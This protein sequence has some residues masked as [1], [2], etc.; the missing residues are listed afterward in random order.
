MQRSRERQLIIAEMR[1][2]EEAA[3]LP[4]LDEDRWVDEEG[5]VR[6]IETQ[7]VEGIY[8]CVLG[9]RYCDVPLF[10]RYSVE[11]LRVLGNRMAMPAAILTLRNLTIML[12]LVCGLL[13]E[14]HLF[15]TMVREL[16][17]LSPL[18][19]QGKVYLETIS[20]VLKH[21]S[22]VEVDQ[23]EGLLILM[24]R[25]IMMEGG[26]REVEMVNVWCG[27]ATFTSPDLHFQPSSLLQLCRMFWRS[28]LQQVQCK[29]YEATLSIA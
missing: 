17:H 22:C 20:E 27:L 5:L 15:E 24:E 26:E 6:A 4:D 13:F 3:R 29:L 1:F 23:L 2:K 12:S 16:S 11:I 14:M 21:R 7:D 18:S 25:F 19:P 28:E 8:E 10:E 9:A